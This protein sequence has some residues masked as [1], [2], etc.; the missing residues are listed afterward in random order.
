MSIDNIEKELEDL[1]KSQFDRLDKHDSDAYRLLCRLGCYRYQ[2][3]PSVPIYGVSCLLWDVP[4]EQHRR[5]IKS[6]QDR[7]L[8]EFSKG[9]YWLHP[10]IRAEAIERL[11][12]EGEWEAANCEA[13]LFWVKLLRQGE[14]LEVHFKKVL[15]FECLYHCLKGKNL[16]VSEAIKLSD[17]LSNSYNMMKEAYELA[18]S[19]YHIGLKYHQVAINFYLDGK[20]KES[21]EKFQESREKFQEA[22]LGFSQLEAL[23]LAEKVKHAL[24]S[25]NISEACCTTAEPRF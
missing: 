5:I 6:L 22:I 19:C 9:E 2:E 17:N 24:D 18:D 25:M 4:K 1:V 10:V 7:S 20:A 16:E 21:Q 23:K 11:R 12:S 13:A 8:L 15:A 14:T 3:I